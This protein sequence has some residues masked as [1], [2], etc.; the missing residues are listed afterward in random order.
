MHIPHFSVNLRRLLVAASCFILLVAVASAQTDFAVTARINTLMAESD[1]ETALKEINKALK[2]D[3][4]NQNLLLKKGSVLVAMNRLDDA[5]SHYKKLNRKIKS[6]PEPSLGLAKVYRLLGS[7]ADSI[8]QLTTVIK[9]FPD[10]PAAYERL[11]DLY[12]ELAQRQY[13][14]GA[15]N[16]PDSEILVSKSE[17]SS[18]FDQMAV[19]NTPSARQLLLAEQEA[20]IEEQKRI[21]EQANKKNANANSRQW[22]PLQEKIVQTL[23]SWANAWS[24]R[25]VDAYLSHYSREFVP[26]NGIGLPEWV[27]RKSGILGDAKFINIVLKDLRITQ[28]S[29]DQ[30]IA[31]FLQEYESNTLTS[32]SVKSVSLKKY[33]DQWLITKEESRDIN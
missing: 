18:Q 22:S 6:S 33:D 26:A 1:Y 21:E 20:A 31:N 23:W 2:S 14:N 11:G 25:S 24:S 28:S 19:D 32:K 17:M 3:K 7:T 12:I 8:K 10:H 15:N 5:K 29:N 30:V 13:A 27:G 4:K 9:R 16:I